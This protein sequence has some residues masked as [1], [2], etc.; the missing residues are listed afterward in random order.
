[1]RDDRAV[2]SWPLVRAKIALFAFLLIL[3]VP[4]GLHAQ[5]AAS[6]PFQ[7]RNGLL[8]IEVS[9]AGSSRP[10]RFLLDSGASKSVIDLTTARRCGLRLGRA[11]LVLGVGGEA[12]ARRVVGFRGQVAGQA[13]P[14]DLLALRLDNVIAATGENCDGLLGADFFRDRIVQVDF[15]TRQFRLLT[16]CPASATAFALPAKNLNQAICVPI[17]VNGR[18]SQWVRV[19]TGCDEALQW[20]ASG[21]PTRLGRKVSIGVSSASP[22]YLKTNVKIG[23]QLFAGIRTGLHHREIFPGEAGLLGNGLL[24]RFRLTFDGV[25]HRVVFEPL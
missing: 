15:A 7:F 24:S 10:L 5:P 12:E 1:L 8:W 6:V 13:L 23:D 14:S 11:V 25:A 4:R 17:A 21:E 3:I 18:A 22:G 16:S 19:D 20:V 2:V 9:A